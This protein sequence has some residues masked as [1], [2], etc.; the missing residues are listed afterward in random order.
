[1]FVGNQPA[2]FV[3][4]DELQFLQRPCS[5]YLTF[6]VRQRRQMDQ[7]RDFLGRWFGGG[8]RL[9]DRLPYGWPEAN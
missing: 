1:M 6:Q 2:S 7:C 9:L 5:A 8:G 4:G 3:D